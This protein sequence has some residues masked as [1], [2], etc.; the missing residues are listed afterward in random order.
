M[1]MS[2]LISSY[3]S[4][5]DK[6]VLLTCASSALR[7]ALSSVFFRSH[8]VRR[9]SGR[10]DRRRP[11]AGRFPPAPPRGRARPASRLSALHAVGRR[12]RRRVGRG[13]PL[14][15]RRALLHLDARGAVPATRPAARPPGSRPAAES[16]RPAR[17]SRSAVV[18]LRDRGQSLDRPVDQRPEQA[19]LGRPQPHRRPARPW[20]A[21]RFCAAPPPSESRRGSTPSVIRALCASRSANWSRAA[22]SGIVAATV[23]ISFRNALPAVRPAS[24][25]ASPPRD[26]A[27]T[28]DTA[29][30]PSAVPRRPGRPCAE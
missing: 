17:P 21:P 5:M 29:A 26:R 30:T 15:Q 16:A 20:P 6:A 18:Q 22:A 11:A 12:R 8:S 7:A 9:A 14:E 25:R 1:V 19:L 3:F 13:R 4:S 27:G 2:C 23:S 28:P 10:P 24:G